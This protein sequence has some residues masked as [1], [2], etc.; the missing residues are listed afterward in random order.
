M[1]IFCRRV[2]PTSGWIRPS[3][4]SRRS[5]PRGW[6][7]ISS[8]IWTE[9]CVCQVWLR[10]WM[11]GK[12][13]CITAVRSTS[14]LRRGSWYRRNGWIRQNSCCC[15]RI[16]ALRKLRHRWGFLI[17]IILRSCFAGRKGCLQ[18]NI[19]GG[20]LQSRS[21]HWHMRDLMTVRMT[22]ILS[23]F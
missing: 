1:P 5:C 4:Y 9:I 13:H 2:P 14:A 16:A 12:P 22:E 7:S 15:S 3:V 18:A 8:G 6:S 21:G 11:W 19:E 17:I 10:S 23:V 20:P